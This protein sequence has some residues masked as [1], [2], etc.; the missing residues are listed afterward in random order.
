VHALGSPEMLGARH[1]LVDLHVAA[2]GQ[3]LVGSQVSA[4]SIAPL[5]HTGMQSASVLA[6]APTGQQPSSCA[7]GFAEAHGSADIMPALP[8]APM[9]AVLVPKF[10]LF[11]P[12]SAGPVSAAAPST[13]VP[14]STASHV[15][16]ASLATVPSAHS[17][18]GT[19]ACM[20][21]LRTSPGGQVTRPHEATVAITATRTN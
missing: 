8:A 2:V 15:Y 6:F 13:A 4:G 1:A 11:G 3:L 5:P 17:S 20:A 12:N 19:H 7:L 10:V 21:S 18:G 14:A 9:L 16:V